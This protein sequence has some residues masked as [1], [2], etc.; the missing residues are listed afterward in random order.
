VKLLIQPDDGTAPLLTG[1]RGAKKSIEIAIFRLDKKDLEAALKAAVGRGVTV[2]AL[3]AFTS[4]NGERML[5]KLELRLLGSGITV[6][7]TADD[8]V[9]YHYKFMIIDRTTL[10]LLAFN[11]TSID[12]NYSRSFGIITKDPA[13]V[14]EAI[15][16]F[17]ADATR[18]PYTSQLD[19]FIVSPVNAR[20][21][22][23]A[24]LKGAQKQLLIYD[25]QLS[26]REMIGILK[27]R[28]KAGVEIKIIGNVGKIGAGL[29]ARKLS[30]LRLHTRTIIRDGQQAFLGSQSLR[31]AE[32]DARREV[33]LITDDA[34]TV[35]ALISTF[36]ADWSG[37][38]EAQAKIEVKKVGLRKAAKAAKKT[39]KSLADDLPAIMPEVQEAVIEAVAE[40]IETVRVKPQH[41]GFDEVIKEAVI[42]AVQEVVQDVIKETVTEVIQDIKIKRE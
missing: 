8:L 42:E 2:K 17:E 32:L 38:E 35:K 26:D 18:Q 27:N 9:R 1:I 5:R 12:I 34:K 20:K 16:L 15:K 23:A 29:E 39:V 33:G 11:Y 21:Q 22:L 40:T 6:A 7:R 10:Y 31:K 36:V 14:Q 3:V 4:R 19:Q 41:N 25:N 28:A 30:G 24:F 37:D 13:L